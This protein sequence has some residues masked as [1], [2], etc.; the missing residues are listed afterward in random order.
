MK[1]VVGFIFFSYSLISFTT[2]IAQVYPDAGSWN[3]FN[4]EVKIN[5]RLSAQFTEEL[6][7]KENFSRLNLLYTNAGLEYRVLK[8]LK[9]AFVYRFI[10]KYQDENYFSLRHR[11]MLDVSAKKKYKK[12]DFAYRFRLQAEEQDMYSSVNGRIPEWYWRN[13]LTAKYDLDKP[14]TPYASVEFR[15]QIRDVQNIES[16]HTWHRTRWVAGVDYK[17]NDYSTF[18]I[19]YLIQHE[20]NVKSPQAQYIIGLEYSL[21]L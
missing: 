12:V 10:N 4:L 5:K 13:K 8:N 9:A 16:D 3:T 2:C 17:K 14:Y 6:R 19:Y 20:Y 21:T 15:Y 11:L 7:F 1:K 18:G